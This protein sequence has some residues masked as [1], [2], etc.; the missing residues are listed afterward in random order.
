MVTNVGKERQYELDFVYS[1]RDRYNWDIGKVVPNPFGGKDVWPD[2]EMA[3]YH[4][5]GLACEYDVYGAVSVKVKWTHGSAPLPANL[6]AVP[7][8]SR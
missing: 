5:R 3:Q 8:T 7:I 2:E 4:L 1:M 6:P